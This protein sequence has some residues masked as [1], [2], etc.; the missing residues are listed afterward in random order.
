M[1]IFQ[2]TQA[3]GWGEVLEYYSLPTAFPLL[4]PFSPL[5]VAA[6]DGTLNISLSPFHRFRQNRLTLCSD[7]DQAYF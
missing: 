4:S 5:K 1:L 6:F 7:K 3:N 2:L